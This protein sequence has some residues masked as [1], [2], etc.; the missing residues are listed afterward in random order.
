MSC[1]LW[2]VIPIGS[3]SDTDICFQRLL[4]ADEIRLCK[5]GLMMDID[6]C[7]QAKLW[8][9]IRI[10][11]QGTSIHYY[12]VEFEPSTLSWS[13]FRGKVLGPTD[14]KDAP[15][16]SLRGSSELPF[17]INIFQQLL[18]SSTFICHE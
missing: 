5:A 12:V 1:I 11:F 17:Y 8:V 2:V 6:V 13:D 15:S 7:M 10:I 14:P 4:H 9:L 18:H 16:D 3:G